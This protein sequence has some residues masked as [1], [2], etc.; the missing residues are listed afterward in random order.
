ML[1]V[2][3]IKQK[4][5]SNEEQFEALGKVEDWRGYIKKFGSAWVIKLEFMLTMLNEKKY[6]LKVE[7]GNKDINQNIANEVVISIRL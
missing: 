1:E 4:V 6:L 2:R 5:G 3:V 7:N